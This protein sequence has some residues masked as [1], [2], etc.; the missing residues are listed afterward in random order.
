MVA[1]KVGMGL[2]KEIQKFK[3][4]E[5]CG[6]VLLPVPR[7]AEIIII[8]PS[9]PSFLSGISCEIKGTKTYV[10]KEF[11]SILLSQIML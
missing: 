11:K 1:N 8:L 9:T 4:E 5:C 7:L 6:T 2:G 3:T 10:L